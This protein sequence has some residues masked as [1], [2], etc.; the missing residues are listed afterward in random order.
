MK[1]ALLSDI[2]ANQLA[3]EACIAHALA[4]GATRFAVLGDI[5][6]Y[7]PQPAQVVQRVRALAAA[8]AV[9]VQG[10]HD[11]LAVAPP[12][13]ARSLDQAGAAWTH[14]RLPEDDLDFLAG[15]PETA[16]DGDALLV[17]AS[18]DA[19]RRWHYVDNVQRAAAS[20]DAACADPRVRRVFGGHVH[21]Q[22]L[23]FRGAGRGLMAFEPTP[24]APIPVPAH[25]RWLATVGSVGQPRD[26]NPAAMYAIHDAARAELTFHRVDYDHLAVAAAVR[27]AGLPESFAWRLERGQ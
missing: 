17:H 19:P 18:A 24:G 22:T 25:R 11:A 14:S 12:A 1:L 9:V 27:A 6:G 4:Q 8:G 23:F 15:L 10:N 2:H 7:G 5:V 20:L 26:G 21:R 16:I 13:T 3:L